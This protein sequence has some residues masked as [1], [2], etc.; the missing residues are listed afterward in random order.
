MLSMGCKK[1]GFAFQKLK[2]FPKYIML[3][4]VFLKFNSRFLKFNSGFL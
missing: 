2:I 4:F 1:E 3:N